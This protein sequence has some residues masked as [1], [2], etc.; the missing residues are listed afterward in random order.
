M[1]SSASRRIFRP[2][3]TQDDDVFVVGTTVRN[4][5]PVDSPVSTVSDLL[6]GAR[7]RAEAIVA[8]A[9]ARA[10]SIVAGAE[11][12][13]EQV[14]RAAEAVGLES[15]KAIAVAD[16]AAALEQVRK[17][18][19]E[20][21]AIRQGMIDEAMPAIA[22][23][24]AMACRR[25]V[26]AT[27]VADPSL[28]AE[29]CLDAVRAAAG[30]QILSIR[31]NP[32]AFEAVRATLVDVADFIRPDAAVELG[33]CFIDLRNGTIDASLDARLDLMELALR[34]AGGAE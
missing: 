12:E 23:A 11:A 27:F 2:I 7:R 34:S 25:I 28:T 14:R 20:G 9:E 19:A 21:L 22:R 8:E 15:G 5:V 4:Y 31:V 29:A 32:D 17:A 18:A 1:S 16:A 30:Q 10:A 33:G 6:E 24:V 3:E 26:G 13:A